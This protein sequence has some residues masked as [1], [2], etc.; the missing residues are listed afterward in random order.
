M[1]TTAHTP[2]LKPPSV[3]EVL[4]RRRPLRNVNKETTENI[5]RLEKLAVWITN[6][7]GTMGFFLA[8]FVWTVIWL[9]WNLLAPPDLQFDPPRVVEGLAERDLLPLGARTSHVDRDALRALDAAGKLSRRGF[10]HELP[11]AGRFA[12]RH[13]SNAIWW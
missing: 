11:L 7:V 4:K 10:E 8:I 3:E 5:G 9:S 1:S 13:L 6:R 12:E 2:S